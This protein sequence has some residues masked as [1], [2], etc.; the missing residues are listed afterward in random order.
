MAGRN[1]ACT[2]WP[3]A[4]VNQLASSSTR[5]RPVETSQHANQHANQQRQHG[6]V[7]EDL[8]LFGLVAGWLLVLT[9]EIS[10]PAYPPLPRFSCYRAPQSPAYNL[11]RPV[12]D[13]AGNSFPDPAGLAPLA[14]IHPQLFPVTYWPLFP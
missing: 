3:A 10:S 13:N 6:A 11:D 8:R 12:A 4:T 9:N 2:G 7:G 1:G 14:T 5:F